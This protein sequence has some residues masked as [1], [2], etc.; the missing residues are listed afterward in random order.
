V[1]RRS[2]PIGLDGLVALP[3][4]A[5]VAQLI[6]TVPGNGNASRVLKRFFDTMGVDIWLTVRASNTRARAFYAKNNMLEVGDISWS[7]G[8]LAG[9]IYHYTS[10]SSRGSKC[11]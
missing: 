5:H 8:S 7:G 6:N 1:Y 2:Q 10:Q 4:D 11:L 3:G 9:K